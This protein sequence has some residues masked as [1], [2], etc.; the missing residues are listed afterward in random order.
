MNLHNKILSLGIL[1]SRYCP[2]Q[3]QHCGSNAGPSRKGKL[4]FFIIEKILKNLKKYDIDDLGISGGEPLAFYNDMLD[5]A[6]MAQQN[7][8]SLTLFSNAFWAKDKLRAEIYLSSLQEK[9]LTSLILSTDQFHQEFIDLENIIIASNIA[10]LLNINVDIM[11]PSTASGWST[12]RTLAYL[13]SK[14]QASL[15]TH[16]IHPIGRA[17]SLDSSY[18][19]WA[20]LEVKG[21]DLVGRIEVDYTALT[22]Q[23]PPA[24]DFEKNNP[25]VLGNLE[26]ESL[27]TLLDK[28]QNN[29]L[30]WILGEFG[31]LGLYYLFVH[32]GIEVN[33]PI[34][35]HVSNCQLCQQLTNNHQFF[36]EF[37]I[38]TSIDLKDA[39]GMT[40]SQQEQCKELIQVKKL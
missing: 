23:C 2:A 26:E 34:E 33:L 31:P 9:G 32:A 29:L 24:S 7:S 37:L 40:L 27:E 8:I 17:T 19:R 20:K 15:T 12:F 30:Y 39:S 28:Y 25:L 36:E 22:A 10:S 21:C 6:T 4:S 5:I 11:I 35:G 16:P 1:Y 3:C 18:F 38:L 13:E 14:T